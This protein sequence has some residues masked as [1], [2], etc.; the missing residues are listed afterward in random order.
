MWPDGIS[1]DCAWGVIFQWDSTLKWLS[2]P[3]LQAGT[4]L[5]WPEI[6][7][8]YLSLSHVKLQTS[9]IYTFCRLIVLRPNILFLCFR[10]S[11]ISGGSEYTELSSPQCCLDYAKFRY[12][13]SFTDSQVNDVK[14]LF[15]IICV[16]LVMS[17]YWLVYFQV[18]LKP[19]LVKQSLNIWVVLSSIPIQVQQK[20][21]NRLLKLPILDI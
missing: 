6:V 16:F 10:S 12:G 5:I 17:P 20:I 11:S 1:Y 13:G 14:K 21:S 9:C 7:V 18:R 4:I 2:Y 15:K 8:K 3:L 19:A